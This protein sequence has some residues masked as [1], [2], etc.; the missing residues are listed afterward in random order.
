MSDLADVLEKIIGRL[1]E[2]P[3]DIKITCGVLNMRSNL[4]SA[5]Q[6]ALTGT[7]CLLK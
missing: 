3:I 1:T 7:F 6:D 4:N 2:Y 5:W